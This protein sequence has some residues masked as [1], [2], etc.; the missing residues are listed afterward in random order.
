MQGTGYYYPQTYA[1]PG[2][3]D[4]PYYGYP[5]ATSYGSGGNYPWPSYP[6]VTPPTYPQYP[7]MP[8]YQPP[9]PSQSPRT[10]EGSGSR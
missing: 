5:Y 7:A 6:M 2:Q 9:V 3:T 10:Y 8:N 1:T 4:N